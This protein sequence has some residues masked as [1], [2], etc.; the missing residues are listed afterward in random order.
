MEKYTIN[1][2]FIPIGRGCPSAHF[3]PLSTSRCAWSPCKDNTRVRNLY[4]S[5][6]SCCGIPPKSS[7]S[8]ISSGSESPGVVV[9]LRTCVSTR[10][11]HGVEPGCHRRTNFV[12]V[13]PSS[14]RPRGRLRR[15][16]R[17]RLCRSVI[18]AYRSTRVCYR[19]L[20]RYC[21]ANR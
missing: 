21:I 3:H 12:F 13:A 10:R 4:R 6:P 5:T 8:A 20:L 2:G 18:P 9:K 15:L 19:Y 7:T 11:R 16:L 17:Q 1:S 14:S